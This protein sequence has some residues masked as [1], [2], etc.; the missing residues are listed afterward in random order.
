MGRGQV[1]ERDGFTLLELTIAV[2]VLLIVLAGTAQAL[3]SY[4]VAMDMNDQRHT[5]MRHCTGVLN[6]MR[7]VRDTNPA[8]FPG[9]I[10]TAW[11]D[12]SE[13][14][15]MATLPEETITVT[16]V[17]VT[18]NPLAVNVTSQWN[19]IRGRTLQVSA[20]TLLTDR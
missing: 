16:Y 15:N 6:Q 9:A 4:Y 2:A 1:K 12:G 17:S 3:V 18:A 8:D 19:D 13:V 20:S 11:P 5:A 7:N 14:Q 10:L